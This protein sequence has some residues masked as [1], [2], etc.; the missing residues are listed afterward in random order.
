[1][2]LRKYVAVSKISIQDNM[3]Y[4]FNFFTTF[5]F[6]LAPLAVHLSLWYAVYGAGVTA[7]QMS[8]YTFEMM[9]TYTILGHLLDKFT[10]EVNLQLKTSAEI[11]EGLISRY[12]IKP[13]DYFL[14]DIS[15]LFANR[16]VY[17][18]TL[19][20]PY[21]AVILVCRNVFLFNFD[22][23]KLFLFVVSIFLAILLSFMVNHLIG[24]VTF[25]LQE[26]T[27]LYV[28][29]QSTF[30]FLAGGY[31]TLDLL[32][33]PIYDFLMNTPFPY[34]LYF[35]V[36][37]YMNKFSMAEAANCFLVSVIWLIVLTVLNKVVWNL[38]IRRY[39]AD[40]I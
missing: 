11:R 38:G 31:F 32:P 20:I 7:K 6:I 25:W 15:V 36:A 9:M 39:T 26:V 19:I 14:Y 8:G 13:I 24:L 3:E 16:T 23:L 5:I 1:M 29:T 22:P 30:L 18:I 37:L 27:S 28:F 4:R 40:G 33:T 12:L 21:L 2:A 10:S 35:P 34:M 17:F